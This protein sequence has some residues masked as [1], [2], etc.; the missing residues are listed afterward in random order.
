MEQTNIPKL[1]RNKYNY[2]GQTTNTDYVTSSQFKIPG[3]NS[4]GGNTWTN[5]QFHKIAYNVQERGRSVSDSYTYLNGRWYYNVTNDAYMPQ[6]YMTENLYSDDVKTINGTS[7]VGAGDIEVTASDS[8]DLSAYM[9]K[10]EMSAYVS[11]VELDNA[12][13]LNKSYLNDKMSEYPTFSNINAMGYVSHDVLNSASY[14]TTSYVVEQCKTVQESCYAYTDSKT[15]NEL[16]YA[17]ITQMFNDMIAKMIEDGDLV[18]AAY[19]VSKVNEV[20]V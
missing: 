10:Q 15:K 8:I 11:K 12:S 14:A 9:T 3:N 18:N 4:G 2:I 1:A 20:R 13:Y 6:V 17:Y 5:Q 16:T 19:V 7:I